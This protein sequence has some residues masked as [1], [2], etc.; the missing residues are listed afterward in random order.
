MGVHIGPQFMLECPTQIV[1][2][3]LAVS[4][5]PSVLSDALRKAFQNKGVESGWDGFL[6]HGD[7]S[8]GST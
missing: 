8:R 7:W 2:L 5:Y 6:G 4:K 1:V 3:A